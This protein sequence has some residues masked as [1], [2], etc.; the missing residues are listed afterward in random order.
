MRDLPFFSSF[1]KT[2]LDSAR[3]N[4]SG[5]GKAL[6]EGERLKCISKINSSDKASTLFLFLNPLVVFAQKKEEAVPLG[7]MT[8]VNETL[9]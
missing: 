1:A 5:I 8:F 4:C 3:R 7:S 6:G 9:N 2:S